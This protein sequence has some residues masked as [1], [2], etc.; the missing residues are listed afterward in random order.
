M[1]ARTR[2]VALAV[3]DWIVSPVTMTVCVVVAVAMGVWLV[4]D[5]PHGEVAGPPV[6]IEYAKV[7][8]YCTRIVVGLDGAVWA[9]APGA[10]DGGLTRVDPGDVQRD[11]P[12]CPR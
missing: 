4:L 8:G 5:P 7:G 1:S 12:E 3:R 6:G 2:T 11:L 9:L 10:P